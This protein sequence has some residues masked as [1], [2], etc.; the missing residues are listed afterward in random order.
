M[1]DTTQLDDQKIAEIRQEFDF[2]DKDQNGQIDLPEFIELLTVL[3]PKTKASHVQ[4][5]FELID[6][7]NDGY[8]DFEEFLQWWQSAWW[9][10]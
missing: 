8:I 9:E 5:G 3:S 6:E 7:N 2:F 4:E 10:Y 1:T